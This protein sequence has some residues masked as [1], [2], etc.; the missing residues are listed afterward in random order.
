MPPDFA[1]TPDLTCSGCGASAPVD[2]LGAGYGSCIACVRPALTFGERFPQTAAH[3]AI[4]EAAARASLAED[5]AV[6]LALIP[7]PPDALNGSSRPA[8]VWLVVFAVTVIVVCVLSLAFLAYL[9]WSD[10]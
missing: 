10:R 5:V 2:E 1:F 4:T 9:V 8:P 7:I 3:D 6:S